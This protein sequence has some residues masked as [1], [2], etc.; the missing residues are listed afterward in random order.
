VLQ[1]D[2][3]QWGWTRGIHIKPRGDEEGRGS[4]QKGDE[5]NTT[6]KVL[7][8]NFLKKGDIKGKKRK[9]TNPF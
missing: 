7:A 4:Q 6:E 2:R 5:E 1:R 9:K 8:E 3:R